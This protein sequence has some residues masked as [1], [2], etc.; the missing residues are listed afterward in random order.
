MSY[1]K[2]IVARTE[3]YWCPIKHARSVLDP[4]LNYPKFFDYGN[5]ERYR[6]ELV[7]LRR[8]Y[9]SPDKDPGSP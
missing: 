3:Q 4:H 7:A 2:E 9:P 8:D 5:V 6:Q 1:A